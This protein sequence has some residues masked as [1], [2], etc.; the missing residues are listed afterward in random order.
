MRWSCV[1][2]LDQLSPHLYSG[3]EYLARQWLGEESFFFFAGRESSRSRFDAL[4]S[5]FKTWK[6]GWEICMR[7]GSNTKDLADHSI[8]DYLQGRAK[9]LEKVLLVSND[10][11]FAEIVRELQQENVTV[12]GITEDLVIATELRLAFNRSYR[13]LDRRLVIR[14]A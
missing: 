3:A 8:I 9:K 11:I 4:N 2:D 10:A 7:D 6:G 13:L 12:R 14:V 5:R 1:F